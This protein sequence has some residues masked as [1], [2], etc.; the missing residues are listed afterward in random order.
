VERTRSGMGG[1]TV[2]NQ[3][4]RPTRSPNPTSTRQNDC[5]SGWTTW[6]S[7]SEL[8]GSQFKAV[9]EEFGAY[10]MSIGRPL[11]RANGIDPDSLLDVGESR[12]LRW[13]VKQLW[14]CL[15]ARGQGK[16]GS[17]G[18]EQDHGIV[19]IHLDLKTEPDLA[20]LI[21]VCI[22]RF[23][24]SWRVASGATLICVC[25][26]RLATTGGAWRVA[27]G[28]WR[29]DAAAL[30][31]GNN[32]P[33]LAGCGTQGRSAGGSGLV[34]H[35]DLDLKNYQRH[36]YQKSWRVEDADAWRVERT[37]SGMGSPRGRPTRSPIRRVSEDPWQPRQGD[38]ETR[39]GGDIGVPNP[40]G[41]R[42]PMATEVQRIPLARRFGSEKL[43]APCYQKFVKI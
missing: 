13:R 16:T 39:R 33:G 40:T 17:L 12:W 19:H 15:G 42:G 41:Q 23:A 32:G 38:K 7:L 31:R 29:E 3:R 4:G 37:R 43:S 24:T 5:W 35:G 25:I 14:R 36:D 11:H 10:A 26:S 18:G 34:V 8:A 1:Q 20:P 6:T 30:A 28:R 9:P 21:C 2:R 27:R 22:G